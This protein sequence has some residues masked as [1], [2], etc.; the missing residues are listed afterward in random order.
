MNMDIQGLGIVRT[1]YSS[2]SK[3]IEAYSGILIHIQPPSQERGDLSYPFQNRKS[4]LILE[5]RP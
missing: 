3:D 2:I 4:V 1:V 5:K